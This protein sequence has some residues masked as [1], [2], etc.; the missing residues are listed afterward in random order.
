MAGRVLN[1]LRSTRHANQTV[2]SLFRIPCAIMYNMDE[3]E[4]TIWQR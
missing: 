3:E 2:C 4:Y 1:A